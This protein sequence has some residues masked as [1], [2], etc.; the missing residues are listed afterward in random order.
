MGNWFSNW[1]DVKTPPIPD[2]GPEEDPI[3][4]HCA[5]LEGDEME[6]CKQEYANLKSENS[7]SGNVQG[8][9]DAPPNTATKTPESAEDTADAK[10]TNNSVTPNTATKT[11]ESAESVEDDGDAKSTKNSLTPNTATKTPE[12]AEISNTATKTPESSTSPKIQS[13][14]VKGGRR[15]RTRK[16]RALRNRSRKPESK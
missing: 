14:P 15:R 10:S 9:A 2:V 7:E 4:T 16:K 5:G 12:S 13:E 3:A 1:K 11:P 6:K 8:T